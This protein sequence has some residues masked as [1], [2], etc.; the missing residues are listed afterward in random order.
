MSLHERLR[1]CEAAPWV[2]KE[3]E[4]IEMAY[5]EQEAEL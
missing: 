3:I 5:E 4:K 1:D 2:I